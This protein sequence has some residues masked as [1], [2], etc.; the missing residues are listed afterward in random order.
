MSEINPSL[1]PAH[2]AIDLGPPTQSEVDSSKLLIQFIQE[3]SSETSERSNQRAIV[4]EELQ[5][6]ANEFVRQVCAMLS[7][8]TEIDGKAVRCQLFHFGSYR[9]GVCS[10]SS[11]IDVLCL[12]P[13]YVTRHH[14]FNILYDLL[15]KNKKVK[16]LQ[17]IEG[18]FVPI[19]T[20]EFDT[21]D[22]DFSF[23]P[24]SRMETIPEDID[25][26]NDELLN[27]LD[28]QAVSSINGVRTNDMMLDLVPNKKAFVG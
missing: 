5:E 23:A 2:E 6:I 1:L 15:V 20:M 17:K 21:V 22:I 24:M 26:S 14:F 8:P 11:D 19:M 13:H 16:G 3:K 25:L 10:Q 7:L 28:I 27:D 12:T 18:A 4:L 9:L